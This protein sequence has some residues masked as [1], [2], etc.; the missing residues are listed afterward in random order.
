MPRGALAWLSKEP[1]LFQ[2]CSLQTI[3]PT[4]ARLILKHDQN[5]SFTCLKASHI[6]PFHS[7]PEM[8]DSGLQR[9][10]WSHPS[11]PLPSLQPRGPASSSSACWAPPHPTLGLCCCTTKN[12]WSTP[13]PSPSPIVPAPAHPTVLSLI[14]SLQQVRHYSA[15]LH[16]SP[17]CYLIFLHYWF[18]P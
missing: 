12:S 17:S 9:A 2:S 14:M 15:Y 18:L 4:E 5:S 8:L 6:F 13:S 7:K 10:L 1:P 16:W 11:S 3:L